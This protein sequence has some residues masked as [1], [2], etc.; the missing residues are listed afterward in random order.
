MLAEE[1]LALTG[2][3]EPD[4]L[5]VDALFESLLRS[6]VKPAGERLSDPRIASFRQLVERHFHEQRP[7]VF[8]ARALGLTPR[9]LARLCRRCLGRT[10]QQVLAGRL[11]G[12]ATRMLRDGSANAGQVADAL[13]FCDPSYFSRFYKRT[14]GRTPREAMAH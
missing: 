4:R 6:V 5:L 11:A 1:L 10:P 2:H 14:T 12:E 3:W 13:G 9:S 7:I 8:Y